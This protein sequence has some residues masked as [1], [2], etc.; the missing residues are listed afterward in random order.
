MLFVRFL[1]PNNSLR[2]K[3]Y[4]E[5]KHEVPNNKRTLV[6]LAVKKVKKM[7]LNLN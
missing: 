1:Q 7:K 4:R 5:C 6:N 2:V 3:I